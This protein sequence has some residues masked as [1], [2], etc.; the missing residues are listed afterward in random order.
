MKK[1]EQKSEKMILIEKYKEA[2]KKADAIFEECIKKGYIQ[3]YDG[4]VVD[5]EGAWSKRRG[6]TLYDPYGM[7]YFEY[8]NDVYGYYKDKYRF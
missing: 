5:G 4:D 3:K 1:V 6:N 8:I 2:Q 7:A